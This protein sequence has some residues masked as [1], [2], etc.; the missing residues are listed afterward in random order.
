MNPEK[1]EDIAALK[2]KADV[3]S[4]AGDV[5]P[6]EICSG[7][8]LPLT[9]QDSN[10]E[11]LRCVIGFALSD[12]EDLTNQAPKQPLRYGHFEIAVSADGSPIELGAGAMAITYRARDT[13]LHSDVAL[14]VIAKNV[15]AHPAARA[16]FLREARAAAKLHHP[17]VAGVS[18]YG[19]QEG[20]CYYVM[21][22]VEGET[23]ETRVQ[24]DGPFPPALA[25]EVC[26]QVT[27]ALAA[28][29]ACG[30]VHRDLK[31][32]NVM[33]TECQGETGALMVKVID[34]GLAK[35]VTAEA[36][37][38]ADYTFGGFVG[39][40][41]FASPE[42]FVREKNNRIDARSDIY[43]LGVTL[44]YVLCGRAPFV[45]RTLDETYSRQVEQALPVEHLAAA[46]VPTRVVALLKSMLAVNPSA[47]PQSARD[48]LIA[49]H[50]CQEQFAARTKRF[51]FF[52]WLAVALALVFAA[53]ALWYFARLAVASPDNTIAILPFENL[54]PEK[55]DAFFTIGVQDEIRTDLARIRSLKVIDPESTR[56]Y[57][58]KNRNLASIGS[59][60][61]V[62]HLMEG[63]V[64]READQVRI[65]IRLVDL[66]DPA[67]PWLKEYDGRLPDVFAL[68]SE[69]TR[70]VANRLRAPLSDAEKADIDEPPTSDLTAYDLY[71]RARE[72]PALWEN[73]AAV[74]R[75]SERKIAL[76]NEAIT[77]DPSFTLA[78][79]ELARAHARM[80]F[81]KAGATAEE[82]SV[83]HRSLAEVALQKARRLRPDLGEVHLAQ[84][85]HFLYV[86]KDMDQAHIETDLARRT[87][88]NNAE[89]EAIA[90]LVARRQG[91]W[92][93]AVWCLTR[94][95]A[96]DPRNKRHPYTLAETYRLLRRYKDFDR[97][98]EQVINMSTGEPGALTVERAI[99]FFESRA[100]TQ[101]LRAAVAAASAANHLEDEDRD[102]YGLLFS[103]WDRD[104]DALTRKLNAMQEDGVPIAGVQHPKT[105]FEALGARTRGDT[106]KA[107][108]AFAAA[109]VQVASA[110]IAD[111][112]SNRKLGL[113]AVI[114]AGLGRRD[115]AVVEARRAYELASKV[116]I[117]APVAACNLA[118]VYAWTGQSDLA[119]AV[120]EEWITRPAGANE[121]DQPTYGDFRLNPVWDP[122]RNDPRFQALV[123]RLAPTATE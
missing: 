104:S 21:E 107:E 40:P 57:P 100:D 27:H 54:S 86:T 24:R 13:V 72:G 28:A 84:A 29:E 90:G 92:N 23:L 83:D 87:L 67:H 32:S 12:E 44:W 41:R 53:G 7:C 88:P 50:R 114:D 109:R 39:T 98:M 59:E 36:A 123:E 103:L 20:E 105:W 38:G 42:Q 8:H 120:L 102:L 6:V 91:R 52:S 9:R 118:V 60:L 119:L 65:A 113:L 63:S 10:G 3:A 101:P 78:Y 115:E 68:Q 106:S 4:T 99:A 61:G 25:L 31:P 37:L 79:C 47:R 108:S 19:E 55:G 122:L 74:R 77:R 18:H 58:P 112:T 66:R 46:R 51:R 96:L 76:L 49:L 82:L 43:S 16:R 121:P 64:R 5:G 35:A 22:L 33:L 70:A 95:V 71:L 93:D 34:W 2:G 17:N 48:L 80:F 85:Y 56:S 30:I 69:I 116:A 45:G 62:R 81:Y 75:D 14:K 11:C 15:A 94:A 1:S 110:V 111:R 89:V 117:D 26:V 73:E 97:T